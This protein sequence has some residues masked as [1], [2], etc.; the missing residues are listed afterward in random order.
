MPMGLIMDAQPIS[1]IILLMKP[2]NACPP[3]CWFP[4]QI[5]LP[6]LAIMAE[7]TKMNHPN[8]GR[9]EEEEEEEETT[10]TAEGNDS[11]GKGRKR[12]IGGLDEEDVISTMEGGWMEK[13]ARKQV[14]VLTYT[15]KEKA[16]PPVQV[17]Y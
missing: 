3:L 10:A 13:R 16:A 8:S 6:P 11:K 7:E 14:E 4:G 17:R 5:P 15:E 1:F 9:Q 12:V 2:T